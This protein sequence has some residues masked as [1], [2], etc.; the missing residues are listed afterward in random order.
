M[1]LHEDKFE[2]DLMYLLNTGITTDIQ[3]VLDWMTARQP[4]DIRRWHVSSGGHFARPAGL[5]LRLL[6]EVIELC[7]AAGATED[8]I[9]GHTVEEIA[10]ARQRNEFGGDP[11]A[12]GG[13]WADCAILLKIFAHHAGIHESQTARAK[14]DVLWRRAWEPG[15]SGALYRPGSVPSFDRALELLR[16]P[17][18]PVQGDA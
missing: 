7:V 1:L 2:P 18:Q 9:I 8:E 14:L 11:L 17:Q 16:E 10:K 5:A 6:R 4:G 3:Q 12:V 13:E 15:A